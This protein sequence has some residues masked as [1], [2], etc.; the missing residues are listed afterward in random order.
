MSVPRPTPPAIRRAAASLRD[1]RRLFQRRPVSVGTVPNSATPPLQEIGRRLRAAREAQGYSLR[2][3]SMRTRISI[4]VLEALEKGWGERLP[5]PAYLRTMLGLLEQHLAIEPGSLEALLPPRSLRSRGLRREAGAWGVEL[6]SIE[7]F[8]TWQGTVLYALLALLLLYALNRQQE[9][10]ASGGAFALRPIPPSPVVKSRPQ[11]TLEIE[12]VLARF[13]EVR[14]LERAR[15]GQ[16]LRLLQQEARR[17]TAPPRSPGGP[18]SPGGP[19]A[20]QAGGSAGAR[21]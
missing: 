7:L 19:S 3:L 9:H 1:W 16:A 5:E 6:T 4:A 2:Q 12:A 10:L 11:R 8:A 21:P 13:P 18:A 17:P 20:P 14:S 15:R